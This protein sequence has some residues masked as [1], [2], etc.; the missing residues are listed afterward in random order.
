MLSLAHASLLLLAP[1]GFLAV[2]VATRT[3]TQ[4]IGPVRRAASLAV[5]C[6]IVLI[7]TLA[8]LRGVRESGI[9]FAVPT[10]AFVV[11][12]FVMIGT[13]VSKCANLN[14]SRSRLNPTIPH[15]ENSQHRP[16]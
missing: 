10:Y 11:T 8:N 4:P 6:L 3:S 2:A 7:L 12:F 1:L 13:G 5:R 16:P 14:V 15:C 9:V